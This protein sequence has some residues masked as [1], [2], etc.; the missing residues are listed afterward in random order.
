M[1]ELL[2]LQWVNCSDKRT[3]HEEDLQ[4]SQNII[5]EGVK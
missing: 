2:L 5:Q 1:Q 4:D 3:L